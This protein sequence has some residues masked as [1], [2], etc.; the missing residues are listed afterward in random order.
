[1]N[2][3]IQQGC[4]KLIKSDRKDFVTGKTLHCCKK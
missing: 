2:G 3:L 4:L 1:M